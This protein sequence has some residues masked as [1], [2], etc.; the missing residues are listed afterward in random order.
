MSTLDLHDVRDS[1]KL[2]RD[3]GT[4]AYYENRGGVRC[5]VCGDPFDEVLETTAATEQVR[6]SKRL[7]LCLVNDDGRIL[8]FTHT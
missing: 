1:L 3:S 6:P 4:S 7:D 5:P 8:L 2:I